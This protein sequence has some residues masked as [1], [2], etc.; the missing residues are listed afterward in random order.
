MGTYVQDYFTA[1]S[2]DLHSPSLNNIFTLLLNLLIS[3]L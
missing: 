1:R 3:E 2:T